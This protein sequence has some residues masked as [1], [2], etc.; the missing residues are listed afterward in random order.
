MAYYDPVQKHGET[1]NMSS[2]VYLEIHVYCGDGIG[3]YNKV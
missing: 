3:H 1:H 2:P